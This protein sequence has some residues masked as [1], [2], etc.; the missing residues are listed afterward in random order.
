MAEIKKKER[1][2]EF[3]SIKGHELAVNI[4]ETPIYLKVAITSPYKSLCN[5]CMGLF[6]LVTID[7]VF[8]LGKLTPMYI[9]VGFLII[10]IILMINVC[11]T[12]IEETVVIIKGL[13]VQIE[14]KYVLGSKSNFIPQEE[15]QTV[16]INEVIYRNRVLFMLTFLITNGN[17]KEILIPLFV[18]SL[19]HLPLL[20]LALNYII[21]IINNTS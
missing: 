1:Q 4:E 14:T 18:E 5:K 3:C 9:I 17:T 10:S 11:W 15:V 8:L 2:N 20:K 13:G 7:A 6:L 12:S 21:A 19:P 16:F